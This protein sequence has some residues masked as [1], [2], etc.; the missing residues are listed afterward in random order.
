MMMAFDGHTSL[1]NQLTEQLTIVG[2]NEYVADK[3][4]LVTFPNG[5]K[6]VISIQQ[7]SPYEGASF[8]FETETWIKN[9]PNLPLAEGMP[10][11]Q[12]FID[13]LLKVA[14]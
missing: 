8:D 14:W 2:S 9:I 13:F 11:I 12:Y 6:T 5:T 10:I 4:G 7:F 3:I 1:F